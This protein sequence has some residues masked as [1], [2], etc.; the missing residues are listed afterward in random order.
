MTSRT[1][2]V[3]HTI[4]IVLKLQRLVCLFVPV[5]VDQRLKKDINSCTAKRSAIGVNIAGPRR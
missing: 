3:V 1:H 5:A 2:Q 4:H